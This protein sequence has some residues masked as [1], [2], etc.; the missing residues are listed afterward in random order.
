[1]T[2]AKVSLTLDEEVVSSAR[3]LAGPRGLSSYVNHALHRQLQH[4]RLTALLAE[5]DAEAGPVDPQMMEEVRRLWPGP[6][7][8][9]RSA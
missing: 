9:S 2:A 1:M 7:A 4:D 6:D 5:L 3:E 8:E